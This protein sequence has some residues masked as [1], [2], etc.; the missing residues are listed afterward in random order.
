MFATAPRPMNAQLFVG[1]FVEL[2]SANR[3]VV[4]GSSSSAL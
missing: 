2:P 3:S 1:A 4:A